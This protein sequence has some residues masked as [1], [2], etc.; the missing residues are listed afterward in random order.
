[1]GEAISSVSPLILRT[2]L[3]ACQIGKA[4]L[5][6]LCHQPPADT[7]APGLAVP[8]PHLWVLVK[9]VTF[10]FLLHVSYFPVVRGDG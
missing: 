7:D 10:T 2:W 3:S 5:V 6:D 8:L 4:V 1:M 9:L